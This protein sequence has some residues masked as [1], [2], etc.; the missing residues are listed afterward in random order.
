MRELR[1]TELRGLAM[2]QLEQA[3]ESI[4]TRHVACSD[5][6]RPW[7]DQLVVQTLMRPFFMI[8]EDNFAYG[9]PEMPFA[10]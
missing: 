10:E 2:V 9:R 4:T 8:V 1:P 7:R 5:D 6:C 3:A